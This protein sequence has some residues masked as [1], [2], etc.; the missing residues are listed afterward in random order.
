MINR[1][2]YVILALLCISMSLIILIHLCAIYFY[3][4]VR[5]YEPNTLIIWLEIELNLIIIAFGLYC[6]IRQIKGDV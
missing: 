4:N 2:K 6:Y 1:L 3:G 5:I